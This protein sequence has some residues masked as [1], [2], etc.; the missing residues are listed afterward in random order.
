LADKNE[1]TLENIR[2]PCTIAISDRMQTATPNL[3]ALGVASR[4]TL[5]VTR[6]QV[7]NG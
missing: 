4:K 5:V 2:F 1:A 3:A 6:E 7:K